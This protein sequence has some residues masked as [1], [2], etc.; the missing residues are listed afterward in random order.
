MTSINYTIV[1][2]YFISALCLSVLG[3]FCKMRFYSDQSRRTITR[4]LPLQDATSLKTPSKLNKI[5]DI[6][7]S[8]NGSA[9]EL[10]GVGID[11]FSVDSIISDIEE[12]SKRMSVPSNSIPRHLNHARLE[13]NRLP[14]VSSDVFLNSPKQLPLIFKVN[15]L[16]SSIALNSSVIV[17]IVYWVLL[18]KNQSRNIPY[19]KW[20]LRTDRH[21]IMLL[22]L[23]LDHFI[24]KLPIRILHFIYPSIFVLLYGIFNVIYTKVEGTLLYPMLDFENKLLWSILILALACLVVVPIVQI[25]SYWCIYRFRDR[26]F[27]SSTT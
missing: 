17:T 8:E 11:V 1:L 12:N 6:S 15:W 5:N 16:F 26:L 9:S 25:F 23:I 19:L 13:E 24:T 7:V 10:I 22:W 2:C 21:G 20:Y 14:S 3:V 4:N 27:R 18:F